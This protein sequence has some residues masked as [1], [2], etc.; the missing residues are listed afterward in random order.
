MDPSSPWDML[1]QTNGGSNSLYG[2]SPQQPQQGGYPSLPNDFGLGSQQMQAAPQAP[3]PGAQGGQDS[4][5]KPLT[6][7]GGAESGRGAS[8]WSFLGEANAR[9]SP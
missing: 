9:N 5:A 6:Q 7:Q 4:M 2:P 8:P 1:L 3:V